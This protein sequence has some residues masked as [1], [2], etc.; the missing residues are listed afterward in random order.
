ME[1]NVNVVEALAYV[2]AEQRDQI[3]QLEQDV[4]VIKNR[5]IR[6]ETQFNMANDVIAE[7]KEALRLCGAECADLKKDLADYNEIMSEM[8]DA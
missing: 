2:I 3:D 8:S 5:A 7:L 1:A 4:D 6:Y